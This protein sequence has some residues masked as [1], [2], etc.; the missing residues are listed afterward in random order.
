MNRNTILYCRFPLEHQIGNG[1]PYFAGRAYQRGHGLGSIFGGLFRA[2]LPLLRRGAVAV[3]KQALHTG[4]KIVGDVAHGDNFKTSFKNRFEEGADELVAKAKRK[5]ERMQEGGG[6][7]RKQR[8]K[9]FQGKV[10]RRRK[11]RALRRV[12]SMFLK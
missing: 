2:A 8:G 7:R 3:G 11:T 10:K 9:G 4:A 1:M 12:P 6:K 5:M